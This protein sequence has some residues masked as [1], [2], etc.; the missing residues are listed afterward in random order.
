MSTTLDPDTIHPMPE[1]DHSEDYGPS[2]NSDSASDAA[3]IWGLLAAVPLA[4]IARDVFSYLYR[5]FS[6]PTP[7]PEVAL[8]DVV[9]P[10]TVTEAEPRGE[11]GAEGV[12]SGS[13]NR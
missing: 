5:R 10:P 3:G 2:D 6:V 9:E 4:A 8:G 12:R 11:T 1:E 7:A 13:A